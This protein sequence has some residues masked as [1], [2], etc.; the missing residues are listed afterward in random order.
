M[1]PEVTDL[2][3]KKAQETKLNE[4][5]NGRGF[6]ADPEQ[7]RQIREEMSRAVMMAKAAIED[8]GPK[9]GERKVDAA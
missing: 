4:Q 2:F 3:E 7:M 8:E 1:T 5:C 6:P 9:S